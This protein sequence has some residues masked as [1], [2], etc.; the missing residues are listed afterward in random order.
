MVYQLPW[1]GT[2]MMKNR[3]VLALAIVV[4]LLMVAGYSSG[5]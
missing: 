5:F 4:A 1:K 3:G 2:D